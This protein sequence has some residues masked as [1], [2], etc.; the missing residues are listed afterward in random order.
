MPC[1]RDRTHTRP[2]F[3]SWYTAPHGRTEAKR[4]RGC[5]GT[6]APQ[7]LPEGLARY[8]L[9]AALHDSRFPPI[10]RAECD[11]LVCTVSFLS[12]K[13]PCRDPWDWVVGVHGVYVTWH[14]PGGARLTA[15]FLP[16]VA[17]AQGWDKR[18]TI[19]HALRKAGW[20]GDITEA[21]RSELAVERYQSHTATVTWAE[22]VAAV[23]HRG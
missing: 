21:L 23:R 3:V 11:A 13:E 12:P 15:T 5:I 1:V 20:R 9:Q 2:L 10:R 8:A 14:A 18:A 16:D 19:D 17:P 6:F 4:L 22:Y 7:A